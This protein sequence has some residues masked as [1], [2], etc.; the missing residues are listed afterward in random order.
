MG[1][2]MKTRRVRVGARAHVRPLS[3]SLALSLSLF[4]SLSLAQAVG[5]AESWNVFT[6]ETTNST[7]GKLNHSCMVQRGV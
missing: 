1:V 6:L 7:D 4:L 5:T 3:R 2:V